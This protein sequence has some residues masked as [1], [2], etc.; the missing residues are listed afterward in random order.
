M[1]HRRTLFSDKVVAQYIG[2]SIGYRLEK[3]NMPGGNDAD[4]FY[5]WWSMQGGGKVPKEE[6]GHTLTL[7]RFVLFNRR[8]GL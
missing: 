3:N 2:S 8:F 4:Q 5:L 1:I 6:K 7:Q